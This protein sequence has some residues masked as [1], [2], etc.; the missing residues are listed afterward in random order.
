[1]ACLAKPLDTD[2]VAP[3]RL[4]L[5]HSQLERLTKMYG[6]LLA[7]T[8][9][10]VSDEELDS[11][12]ICRGAS[13]DVDNLG[14]RET[15]DASALFFSPCDW[16]QG[17]LEWE[18][19]PSSWGAGWIDCA[20]G[21]PSLWSPLMCGE[22]RFKWS[23]ARL[24][25]LETISKNV[26]RPPVRDEPERPKICLDDEIKE[27]IGLELP[28]YQFRGNG[29]Y[30]KHE[31]SGAW[32]YFV[33]AAADKPH[34]VC[35]MVDS[36]H[37]EEGVAIRSEVLA[38]V[39][40]TEFQVHGACYTHHF[41][42]PVLVC[43]Y[44][45]NETARLT[46]AHFD[47]KRNMLVLRQS[48]VLDLSGEEPPPDAW[49]MLRWMASGPVGQTLYQPLTTLPAAPDGDGAKRPPQMTVAG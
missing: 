38:A 1:M 27:R 2:A 20:D 12:G 30:R 5:E 14:A 23:K 7:N 29:R 45:G 13:F 3:A 47:M 43:T 4:A 21:L 40:M 10:T 6:C 16:T 33:E 42:K 24:L 39:R 19:Y 22:Y 11:L 44:F 46:Q 8:R 41:V 18:S 49:L 28:W 26:W 32:A 34:S 35:V 15:R 37:P 48:R 9:E 17:S 25:A 31:Y 36:S